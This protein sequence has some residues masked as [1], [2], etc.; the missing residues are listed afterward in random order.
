VGHADGLKC[1]G[2]KRHGRGRAPA[3]SQDFIIDSDLGWA[4]SSGLAICELFENAGSRGA[5]L[6]QGVFLSDERHLKIVACKKVSAKRAEVFGQCSY[7]FIGEFIGYL[8]DRF[9]L[10]DTAPGFTQGTGG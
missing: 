7:F 6:R 4:E 10:M 8:L 9:Q 5:A 3:L 1:K 2:H